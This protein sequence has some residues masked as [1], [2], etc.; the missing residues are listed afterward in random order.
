[1]DDPRLGI[2]VQGAASYLHPAVSLSC[3][4]AGAK[5]VPVGAEMVV[6]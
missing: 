2:P 1:V 5:L 4:V 3:T 6:L